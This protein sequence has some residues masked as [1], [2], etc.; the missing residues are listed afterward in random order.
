MKK[1]FKE[2]AAIF[3]GIGDE[4]RLQIIELLLEGEK[5]AMALKE[6]LKVPQSTLSYHM[7]V[8]CDS[9]IVTRRASGKWAFY[10]VS[11]EGCE[12]AIQILRRY[13]DVIKKK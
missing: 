11:N 7:K 1:N 9:G 13:Q 3:Q 8:L 10:Q 6:V 4:F 5:N 2:T 12:K